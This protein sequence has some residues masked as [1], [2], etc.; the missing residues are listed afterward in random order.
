MFVKTRKGKGYPNSTKITCKPNWTASR[1]D[2]N[3]PTAN[4]GIT[5]DLNF[6]RVILTE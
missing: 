2:K 1:I 4:M 3:D 6:M 5:T